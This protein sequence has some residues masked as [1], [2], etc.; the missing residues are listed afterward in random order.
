[1]AVE[2]DRAVIGVR[3][4]FATSEVPKRW[5]AGIERALGVSIVVYEVRS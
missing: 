3:T 5:G 4:R 1:M 2:G